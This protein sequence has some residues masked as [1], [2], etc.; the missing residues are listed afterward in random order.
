MSQQVIILHGLP[1]SGKTT[2]AKDY[3]NKN[4]NFKRISRDDFRDMLDNYSLSNDL[5]PVISELILNSLSILLKA[6]YSVIIDNTNLKPKYIREYMKVIKKVDPSIFVRIHSFEDVDYREIIERDAKRSRSVGE[7]V[8]KRMLDSLKSN[9]ASDLEKILYEIDDVEHQI[10]IADFKNQTHAIIC[11]I[12]GTIA[13]KSDRSPYDWSKVIEDEPDLTIGDL[14]WNMV[15]VYGETHR[16]VGEQLEIIYLSGRDSI[17]YDDTKLWLESHGFPPGHLFMREHN[18]QRKDSIVKYELFN[19]HVRDN[20]AVLFVLDD[21]DQ[22]VEMWR[23]IGLKC[24]QVAPG[25]F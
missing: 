14:L 17:C 24:L 15:R 8:I 16:H 10:Y 5:E 23:D 21:R 4:K 7:D 2:F 12:D 25:D 13:H 6:K 20:Y 22:V 3:I 19:N 11:D 9:S 1:G 18:D